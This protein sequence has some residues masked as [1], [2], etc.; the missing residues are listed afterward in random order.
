MTGGEEEERDK[1]SRS[2]EWMIGKQ[3]NGLTVTGWTG[4]R[5][6]TGKAK[7]R[8]KKKNQIQNPDPDPLNK[9]KRTRTKKLSRALFLRGFLCLTGSWSGGVVQSEVGMRL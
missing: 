3:S 7:N 9:K 8:K 4:K 5:A 1:G 2:I 6:K